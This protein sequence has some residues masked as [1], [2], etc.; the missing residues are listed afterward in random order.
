MW[1]TFVQRALNEVDNAGKK[2]FGKNLTFCY[3]RI[4]KYGAFLWK[5]HYKW[6]W[7]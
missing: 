5:M 4:S 2:A 6:V 1:E 3:D 7:R